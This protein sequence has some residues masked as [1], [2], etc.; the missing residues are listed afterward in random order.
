VTFADQPLWQ[1]FDQYWEDNGANIWQVQIGPSPAAV[2]TPNPQCV[3]LGEQSYSAFGFG[4]ESEG[5]IPTFGL[6]MVIPIWSLDAAV[7]AGL[8]ERTTAAAGDANLLAIAQRFYQI[9]PIPGSCLSRV[10]V[11]RTPFP[12][13]GARYIL[14]NQRTN[15]QQEYWLYHAQRQPNGTHYHLQIFACDVL[16]RQQPPRILVP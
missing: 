3:E 12:N 5:S 2:I 7:A 1:G 4:P 13:Y 15:L 11:P 6:K 9:Q 10:P 8:A 16:D 14:T